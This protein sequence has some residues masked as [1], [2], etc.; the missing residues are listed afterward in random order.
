MYGTWKNAKPVAASRKH[1]ATQSAAPPPVSPPGAQNMRAKAT[2]SSSAPR[3][4]QGTRAP[5]REV[6]RSLQLPTSGLRSTSH[7]LGSSTTRPATAAATP[8]SSV[9]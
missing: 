5:Q 7:A 8:S 4:I 9:R 2:G 6:V 1:P 3:I